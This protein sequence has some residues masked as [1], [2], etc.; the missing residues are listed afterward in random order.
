MWLY[1]LEYADETDEPKWRDFGGDKRVADYDGRGWDTRD[2][3]LTHR[4]EAVDAAREYMDSLNGW[5]WWRSRHH[6]LTSCSV[7]LVL[8]DYKHDAK[9]WELVCKF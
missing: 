8:V 2:E 3:A 5:E 4:N 6:E 7:W 1:W 9:R